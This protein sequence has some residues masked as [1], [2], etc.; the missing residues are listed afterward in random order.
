MRNEDSRRRVVRLVLLAVT[1]LAGLGLIWVQIR[2]QRSLGEVLFA[3]GGVLASASVGG[4]IVV[5]RDGHRTGWFLLLIGLAVV[6]VDGAPYLPGANGTT[7]EWIASWGWTGVFALFAGLT[8][9]FPSGHLPSGV[10]FWPRAGRMAA[11]A[12]P[13]LVAMVAISAE[14]IQLLPE[15][16]TY[17]GL[18]TVAGILLG[19]V[20]SLVVTRRRASGVERAQLTWVVYGF[21]LL[22]SSILLTFLYVLGSIALGAGDPGDSAWSVAFLVMLLLPLTFGVAVLRYR[23][24]DIDRIFSRTVTYAV[25]AGLLASLYAGAVFVLR[26]RL[27]FEGPLPVAASTLAVAAAFNPLRKWVQAKVD[28]RFNRSHYDARLVVDEFAGSLRDGVDPD[29]I[30]AGWVLAVSETM[31]P[32][33]VGVWLS[34]GPAS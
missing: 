34:D 11:W 19:G 31:Q 8:L 10:R 29:Q 28:R 6:F 4:L 17:V 15:E 23:L 27:P 30:V 13:F 16:L 26:E 9:T 5:R 22:I 2:A 20:A 32:S 14:P 21:V 12:L 25:V 24:Y 1:V 7:A 3:A 18:A 33:M